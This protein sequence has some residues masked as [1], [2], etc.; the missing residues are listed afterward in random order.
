MPVARILSV[1]TSCFT[2]IRLE[3]PESYSFEAGQYAS[4]GKTQLPF[5]IASAPAQLPELRF[6][7][8]GDGSDAAVALSLE[9]EQQTISI[10]VA[11]GDVTRNRSDTRAL[12]LV[13]AGTGISQ[14]LSLIAAEPSSVSADSPRLYW[15]R[16]VADELVDLS[17]LLQAPVSAK[18]AQ[19]L[20]DDQ[21]IGPDNEMQR[22]LTRDAR[23]LMDTDIVVCGAPAFAY[24]CLDS[25]TAAGVPADAI[26]ADAFSYA[27]RPK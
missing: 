9:L 14:A 10:G 24:Q 22:Q 19:Y 7:F 8:R 17:E 20:C 25:L 5:S 18:L 26:R 2:D 3:A 16:S 6:L 13:C 21:T 4:L 23:L 27:P 12:T 1:T 11:S 15:A